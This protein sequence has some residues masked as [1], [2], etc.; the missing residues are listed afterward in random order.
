MLSLS[1]SCLSE[2]EACGDRSGACVDSDNL[3][4]TPQVPDKNEKVPGCDANDVVDE[5][6]PNCSPEEEPEP[7]AEE[8]DP[9]VEYGY[10]ESITAGNFDGTG[11]E[12]YAVASHYHLGP[13]LGATSDM[14][15][16]LYSGCDNQLIKKISVKVGKWTGGDIIKN[17]G[18]IDKDGVDDIAL[19]LVMRNSFLV[20]SAGTEEILFSA[21]I[22]GNI[23][24][25]TMDIVRLGDVDGDTFPDLAVRGF[26][27]VQVHSG[28]TG[29]ALFSVDSVAGGEVFRPSIARAGDLND[30]GV[31][32]LLIGNWGYQYNEGKVSAISGKDFSILFSVEHEENRQS[33]FGRRV[34]GNGDVDGD[35]VKDFAVTDTAYREFSHYGS[36]GVSRYN[37]LGRVYV[38]SGKTREVLYTFTGPSVANQRRSYFLG[39]TYLMIDGD[40]NGD[41][42]SD[43]YI[44]SHPATEENPAS[45]SVY[46]AFIYS[47]KDGSLL[48][49]REDVPPNGFGVSAIFISDQNG[50]GKD[51]L[52]VGQPHNHGDYYPFSK[53]GLVHFFSALFE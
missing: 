5:S 48:F 20:L 28:Q 1:V 53:K 15:I 7:P 32:D 41:G 33:V 17:I 45:S 23:R 19:T 4:Q 2:G 37:T 40:F 22:I 38:Y 44:G 9:V 16:H 46:S 13:V 8:R 18:D 6:N 11:C 50:D 12:D 35:G 10:G 36:N 34:A 14:D 43:I 21:E 49:S 25:V 27:V 31:E 26:N 24:P 30:D 39:S 51:D 42:F 52:L 3:G 29:K 47:G